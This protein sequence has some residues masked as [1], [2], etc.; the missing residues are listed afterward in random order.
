MYGEKS[1]KNKIPR[2]LSFIPDKSV[3][4]L[5]GTQLEYEFSYNLLSAGEYLC[6]SLVF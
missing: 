4:V 3:D 6:E 5:F 2:V 1:E